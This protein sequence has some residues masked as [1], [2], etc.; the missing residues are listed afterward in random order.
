MKN[1]MMTPAEAA[2]RIEA[3]AV[4]VIAGAE[5]VLSALPRGKW[6][7]GTSVYFLTDAGGVCDS[8][9]VF[10][11]EIP[12]AMGAR[13]RHVAT[14]ALPDLTAQKFD[15]GVTM[16]LIPAASPAHSRFAI[17]GATYPGLFDQ[18][19][20]GWITGT[21]LNDLGKLAPKIVDGATG[22]VHQDGAL[23]LHVELPAGTAA[24]LDITNLFVQDGTA[25]VITFD[26]EG[27][28]ATTARVNGTEVNLAGYLAEKGIGA[29]LPL[30]ADYAGAMINVSFQNIDTAAGRVDFYAPVM[31]GTEYRL[32]KSPG[33]Y[34]EVFAREIGA[35]SATEMS[36]NCILN[37]LYGQLEGKT[38]GAY[39]GPATFGEIAYILLNQTMVHLK[40][41]PAA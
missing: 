40:L 22:Q 17:E 32:A 4:L 24:E 36:C 34:A 1:A 33:D 20:M 35:G 39:T 30:V 18:P 3:G 31:T 27:F 14:E 9:R 10:V 28:S 6:I 25:D 2:A 26:S 41:T 19:V 11:T 15:N 5:P 23:L 7:G 29:E 12:E 38:T 16:I 37:Y 8:E 13:V 21:H